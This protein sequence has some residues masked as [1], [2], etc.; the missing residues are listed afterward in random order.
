[1][2]RSAAQAMAEIC[3]EQTAVLGVTNPRAAGKAA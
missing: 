3:A 2:C 1:V